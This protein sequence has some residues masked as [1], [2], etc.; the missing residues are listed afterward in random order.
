MENS[1]PPKS[2]DV[3]KNTDKKLDDQ[4]ASSLLLPP[5][6]NEAVLGLDGIQGDHESSEEATE[7]KEEKKSKKK[8]SD[9]VFSRFIPQP[10]LIDTG[11]DEQVER[12]SWATKVSDLLG[13]TSSGDNPSDQ[14]ELPPISDSVPDRYNHIVDDVLEAEVTPPPFAEGSLYEASESPQNEIASTGSIESGSTTESPVEPTEM[15]PDMPEAG[16]GGSDEPPEL[17]PTGAEALPPEPRPESVQAILARQSTE[18]PD[19]GATPNE[20]VNTSTHVTN[21]YY[22]RAD[23]VPALVVDQ[24]SRRRDR[25][26]R[27]HDRAQ[28][29]NIKT[30]QRQVEHLG[31]GLE[32]NQQK[33]AERPQPVVR[34]AAEQILRQTS[35]IERTTELHQNDKSMPRSP[36]RKVASVGPEETRKAPDS[37]VEQKIKPPVIAA[38]HIQKV[39]EAAAEAAVPIE[40]LYEMRHEIK[41]NEDFSAA[42]EASI[43]S[44]SSYSNNEIHDIVRSNIEQQINTQPSG[45]VNDKKSQLYGQA[46]KGGAMAAFAFIIAFLI[47]YFLF[48]RG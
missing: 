35:S 4:E 33:A 5:R 25:K 11:G 23:L 10:D 8:K 29:R 34:P 37:V 13:I 43:Q 14:D 28:D 21:N 6:L 24:L 31:Q 32:A 12:S 22:Q 47:L 46:A 26:I 18:V 17:P 40:T 7:D 41:G 2:E 42:A 38:E 20:H 36:E 16:D 30:I 44:R 3:L 39:V 45:S 48:L 19:S 15:A 1:Q 27:R 9:K